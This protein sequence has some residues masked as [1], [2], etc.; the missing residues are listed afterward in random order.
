MYNLIKY[1]NKYSKTSGS[2]WQY[3]RVEPNANIIDSESFKFKAR[4]TGRM[5]TG[6][7]TNDVVI[8]DH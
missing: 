7:N 2:L 3:C 5:P 8:T 4:I 1:S 6:G